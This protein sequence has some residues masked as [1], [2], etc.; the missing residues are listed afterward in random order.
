MSEKVTRQE[1]AEA[2]DLLCNKKRHSA[3][4]LFLKNPEKVLHDFIWQASPT[5]GKEPGHAD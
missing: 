4:T 1:A 2:L 3:M 5:E